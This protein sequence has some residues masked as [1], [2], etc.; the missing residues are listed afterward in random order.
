MAAPAKALSFR[1]RGSARLAHALGIALVLAMSVSRLAAQNLL[2]IEHDGKLAPVRRVDGTT[3]YVLDGGKLTAAFGENYALQ[4]TAEYL[5]VMVAVGNLTFKRHSG[6][7]PNHAPGTIR[8]GLNLPAANSAAARPEPTV[9]GTVGSG[10]RMNNEFTFSA[11]FESPYSLD[12]VFIVLAMKTQRE[13]NMLYLHD[14]GRL[15]AHRDTHIEITSRM[16]FPLGATRLT[17]HIFASGTEVLNSRIPASEREAAL[18]RMVGNRIAS[19]QDADLKPLLG[20]PPDYPV[21][22]GTTRLTGRAEVSFRVDERGIVRDPKVANASN[23]AFGDAAL[24]AIRQW[25][26]LPRVK[27]G[28]PVGATASLPFLF[29]PP[30]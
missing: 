19:V 29:T 25:R 14:I 9:T 26:F 15:D 11:D 7:L 10:G 27:G 5:P 4:P 17:I 30:S 13:G 2:Y 16:P 12:N 8:S 24:A 20:P 22:L 18:D 21:S 1:S 6:G 28:H 23:P 3:P